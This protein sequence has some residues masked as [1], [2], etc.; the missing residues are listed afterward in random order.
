MTDI[1]FRSD[2]DVELVQSVGG[3][4]SVLASMLVSTQAEESLKMLDEDPEASEGRIRFL[5]KNR[6]GTPFEHNSMTFFVRAP[7]AVFRE[8]HRHRVGISINEESGR[9]KQLDPVFYVPPLERP[10]VQ[11][12]KPGAYIFVP[13]EM[14]QWARTTDSIRL[15]CRNAYKTYEG[16]LADGV[17]KEV[18]RGVLPVYIYSSMYWTCN[19]RSAMA[20][21][22]L[23]TSWTEEQ[24]AK[25]P[26]K[27]M[28]EIDMCA[29]ILEQAFAER[30]PLTHKAFCD[31]GRVCP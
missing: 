19:A 28:W 20:F 9:Y 3:D 6:H 27:P 24:G 14:D 1:Q 7:I 16:L 30:F 8:W 4:E 17:A 22:S 29:Q 21:L 2:F 13:G 5:M 15:A 26:S 31:F 25:F 18:A 23:R 10:L 12:G 11:T